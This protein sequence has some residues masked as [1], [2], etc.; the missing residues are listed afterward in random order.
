MGW[1]TMSRSAMGGHQTAKAYLD[2]QFTYE[3]EIEG[4]TRG[5]KV[6]A[7]SCSRNRVYYAATQVM[8]N[9]I[10]GD[11]GGFNR[12]SQRSVFRSARDIGQAL[13]LAFPSRAF[14]AVCH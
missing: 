5:L 8:T 14:C 7:S 4:V 11:V 3:R 12:S 13:R 9:G 1:L 2:D 10:G 6:L